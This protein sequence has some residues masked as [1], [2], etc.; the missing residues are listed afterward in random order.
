[1]FTLV[2]LALVDDVADVEPVLQ[3]VSER[4]HHEAPR[5]NGF[6]IR[7]VSR[8]RPDGFFF[9]RDRELTDRVQAPR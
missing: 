7:K 3:Q 9:Q 8:S 4:A 2:N 1:M 6:A 5:G